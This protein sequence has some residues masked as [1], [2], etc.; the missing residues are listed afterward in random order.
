MGINFP[1]LKDSDSAVTEAWKVYVYPSNFIVDKTGKLSF[2]ATGA[3]D[4]QEPEI[5]SVINGLIKVSDK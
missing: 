1:I 2:A 4:W 5:E 3:M